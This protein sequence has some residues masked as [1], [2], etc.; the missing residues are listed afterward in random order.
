MKA[1]DVMAH[2]VLTVSE[3]ARVLDAAQLM[4]KRHISGLPVV[5]ANGVLVGM[6][7]EGDLLRRAEL[8]TERRRSK[9]LTFIMG[10]GQVADEYAHAHGR[11]VKEVM[12]NSPISVA[13]DATIE[14]IIALFE[15][16]NIRRV[17]V[18]ADGQ[19]VGIVTRANVVQALVKRLQYSKDAAAS[20]WAIREQILA[21][22]LKNSWALTAA[23]NV[24]VDAGVVTLSGTILDPRDRDALKVLA[25][26]VP[27]VRGVQDDMIW[28]EPYS[29]IVITAAES[30]KG[31][32]S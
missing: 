20:D 30:N 13:E 17:P 21:E 1:R 31:A 22:M 16:H 12:S 25:E 28:V 5:D 24:T 10:P 3:N 2:R 23:L 11:L 6:I 15:K 27:G 14:R 19:L 7:T 9:V 4:I 26:N 18:V 32:E 8:A 29:G